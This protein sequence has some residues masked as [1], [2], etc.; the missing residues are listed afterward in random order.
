MFP[1]LLNRLCINGAGHILKIIKLS[2]CFTEMILNII[3]TVI[4]RKRFFHSSRKFTTINA[5][6]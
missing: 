2:R 3:D 6:E 4:Q 1:Y 5:Y